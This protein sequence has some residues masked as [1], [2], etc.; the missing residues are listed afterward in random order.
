MNKNKY[1]AVLSTA[2]IAGIM[3]MA[4]VDTAFAADGDF[5]KLD[6]KE[7]VLSHSQSFKE[8]M[9]F[10][11]DTALT[12]DQYG[13]EHNGKVYNFAEVNTKVG[14]I[15]EGDRTAE[16]IF[17]AVETVKE[18]GPADDFNQGLV[19]NS[20][21]A[22]TES[23][24]AKAGQQ[25][26]FAING[27]TE[28]ADVAKLTEAGYTVKFNSTSAKVAA[29]GKIADA[30]VAATTFEYEVVISKD[31][32]EV[33][34]S[35][36]VKVT[37][38]DYATTVTEITSYTLKTNKA[39]EI[40]S[41]KIALDDV[42]TLGDVK[43]TLLAGTEDST[44]ADATFKSSDNKVVLIDASGK[45]TPVSP[46]SVVLTITKGDVSLE[47]P[48]VIVAE[49][50]KATT[51]TADATN[52]KL[53]N[54]GEKVVNLV[55]KDQ[56]DDLFAGLD[57]DAINVVKTGTEDKIATIAN[58]DASNKD[59]KV[60]LTVTAEAAKVGTGNIEIKSDDK[61]LLSIPVSVEAIGENVTRK[62]ETS[63]EDNVI[64]IYNA[65]DNKIVLSYNKYN[66]N[67]YLVGAETDIAE[68]GK[69][70]AV[71]TS[72]KDIATVAVDAKGA[73]S[74]AAGTKTGTATINILEGTVVRASYTV[75]VE[76]ST[77]SMTGVTFGSDLTMAGDGEL[78]LNNIVKDVAITGDDKVEINADGTIYI[79]VA[80]DGYSADDDITLGMINAKSAVTNKVGD[81]A[82]KVAIADSKLKVT[83][84]AA[85]D[86]G[87]IVI[88][89]TAD[90]KTVPVDVTTIT[91]K[92]AE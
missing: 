17:K 19:V 77:P 37:V 63:A 39:V 92:A 28:A 70:Y 3:T 2:A 54:S 89:I 72:D 4:T 84:G 5:Y 57:L 23:I 82:R 33:A 36:L 45:I 55:V 40:K 75:K 74:V 67:G 69:T 24:D 43:G 10:A 78:A 13:Y 46:G 80:N 87:E 56:Y 38:V 30:L 21:K 50:R 53:V 27:K 52:V 34:K 76:D 91:V 59:G 64:D 16:N 41:G 90:G 31:G 26:K 11:F 79:E 8:K 6:T 83:S 18:V 73:I 58:P 51:V 15:P 12:A 9:H 62:L 25:L 42:V 68:T 7:M 22:I 44:I 81:T 66:E 61:T 48:V 35:D 49:S 20:V 88:T 65:E 14:A 60:E 1:V 47:V 86:K 85:D 29:D 32:K 71:T